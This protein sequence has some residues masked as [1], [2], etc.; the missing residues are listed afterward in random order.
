MEK[1]VV[2]HI[3]RF[4][5]DDVIFEDITSEALIPRR[6]KAR[7]V[8]I[9][10]EDGVIAGNKFIPTVLRELGLEVL[11]YT[12]DGE[13]VK[14][15]STILEIYG[16]AKTIL[17]VERTLLNFLM[18][19]SGI[20]TYTRKLVEAVK[21]INNKVVIAATRKTH[22]GLGYFEKYAVAVGGGY[23]HRYG[24]FDMVLIKDNHLAI[25]KDI[26]RAVEEARKKYGMFKKIE[27]EV[28]S[29]EEALEAAKVG[30]DI[31][32]LDN[33]SVNEV[34]KTLELLHKHKLRS[35]VLVEVSGGIDESNILEY[36]KLDID[37]IS[38]SK[39]TLGSPPLGMKLEIVEVEEC[40]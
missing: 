24:L 39:I 34:S 35:R 31:V 1:I 36:A 23:T 33:M 6:C 38:L 2:E 9:A 10:E 28:R 16:E 37:I 32:M 5:K 21:K 14:K 29:A 22:P 3:L 4:L 25:V 26:R 13:L 40:G 27:V 20:A 15:G 8:V 19:L 7:A 30:A 17:I 12:E 11:R 18:V